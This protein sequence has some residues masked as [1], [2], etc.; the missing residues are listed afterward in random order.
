MVSLFIFFMAKLVGIVSHRQQFEFKKTNTK[1]LMKFV[2]FSVE[3]NVHS[4]CVLIPLYI[5]QFHEEMFEVNK[6]LQQQ[7][8]I[9]HL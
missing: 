7:Q 6:Y 5:T 9:L 1:K 8:Q 3:Q 2:M 4:F